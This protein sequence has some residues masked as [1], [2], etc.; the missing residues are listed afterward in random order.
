MSIHMY[1][2]NMNLFIKPC[3]SYVKEQPFEHQGA[4]VKLG[5]SKLDFATITN[6]IHDW[7][8][9]YDQQTIFQESAA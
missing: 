2:D 1:E 7:L 9:T 6:H 8:S 3:C 5:L 4:K